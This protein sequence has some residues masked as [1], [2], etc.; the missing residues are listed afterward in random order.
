MDSG[1]ERIWEEE[2]E[3]GGR[4]AGMQRNKKVAVNGE[5]VGAEREKERRGKERKER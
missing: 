4:G 2:N 3:R 5:S 1:G